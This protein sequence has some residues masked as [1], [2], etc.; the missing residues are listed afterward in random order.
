MS[1][2]PLLALLSA[3]LDAACGDGSS[4]DGGR[5]TAGMTTQRIQEVFLKPE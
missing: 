1:P 3:V 5:S 4:G 2:R